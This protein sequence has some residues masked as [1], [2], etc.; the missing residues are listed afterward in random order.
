[1]FVNDKLISQNLAVGR[2]TIPI[3]LHLRD[4]ANKMDALRYFDDSNKENKISAKIEEIIEG[5]FI[6]DKRI[7]DLWFEKKSNINGNI[8]LKVYNTALGARSFGIIDVLSKTGILKDNNILIIDEPESHLHPEWQHK[9]AQLIVSLSNAGIPILITSH[10]VDMIQK[11]QN[12]CEKDGLVSEKAKFYLSDLCDNADNYASV[13]DVS[14]DIDPI[15]KKL[16][17]PLK[18]LVFGDE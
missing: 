6:Y 2:A 3:P 13:G 15:L 1:A 16:N 9:Y 12:S 14:G 18:D 17:N 10:S 11:I 4:F 5:R 8:K 7:R